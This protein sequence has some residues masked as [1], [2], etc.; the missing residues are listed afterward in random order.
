[1]GA[2]LLRSWVD[3]QAGQ[4]NLQGDLAYQVAASATSG[5]PQTEHLIEFFALLKCVAGDLTWLQGW[6]ILC[7]CGYVQT[8]H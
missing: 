3:H 5:H 1:M 6:P 2:V 7:L 8:C 4:G